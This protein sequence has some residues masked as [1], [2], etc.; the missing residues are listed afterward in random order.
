MGVGPAGRW[1]IAPK[2]RG[3]RT[4]VRRRGGRRVVYGSVERR[5]DCL[6]LVWR[7]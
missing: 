6:V 1:F 7:F 4:K 3:R 2:V 5:N